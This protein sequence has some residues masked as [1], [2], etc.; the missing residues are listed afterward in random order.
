MDKM[1]GGDSREILLRV[2]NGDGDAFSELLC[3]YTPLV[4]ATVKDVG[5][6][7]EFRSEA[8]VALYKAALSYDLDQ[9]KVTFG[10]YARICIVRRLCD[11]A[12][13]RAR[14]LELLSDADVDSIAVGDGI[15]SRL[16]AR[17]D[18]DM[19]CRRAAELLSDYEY[20]IFLLWLGGYGSAEIADR[21]GRDSKSVEN[22][23]ARVA[24]K[25]RGALTHA[26]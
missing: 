2:K 8:C 1:L 4:N 14:G 10:L 25:L 7:A 21:V 20:R 18:I 9:D 15:I 5:G 22:A 23:K 3:A 12:R 26:E 13:N 16:E 24:K 19:L 17:E 11:M 6:D